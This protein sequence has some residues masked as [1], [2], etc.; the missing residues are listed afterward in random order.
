M[1]V[2]SRTATVVTLAAV[3]SNLLPEDVAPGAIIRVQRTYGLWD[4]NI[5]RNVTHC[6]HQPHTGATRTQEPHTVNQP[7]ILPRT[8]AVPVCTR[9]VHD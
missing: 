4:A 9:A 5:N 2:L 6:E 1:T 3:T 8:Q 7:H